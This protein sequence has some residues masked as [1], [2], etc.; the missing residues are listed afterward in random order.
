MKLNLSQQFAGAFS[1]IIAIL[2]GLI[3][4]NLVNFNKAVVSSRQVREES[5][6]FAITAK[7]LQKNV[8]QV[9]QFLTDVSATHDSAGY[10]EAKQNAEEFYSHISE[11]EKMFKNENDAENLKMVAE[12]RSSF[13]NFYKLG[14]EMAQA[15]IDKGMDAG[16]T[17]MKEFDPASEK[18]TSEVEK[19]ANSQVAELNKT[20]TNVE[21]ANKHAV[22]LNLILGLISVLLAGAISVVLS[23]HFVG[24]VNS[25]LATLR[26]IASGDLTRRVSVDSK[27]ELG[28]MAQNLNDTIKKVEEIIV[29][30]K[31]ATAQLNA[32]TEEISSSS[33]QISDGAQQQSASFEQLTSSVQANASNAASANEIAQGTTKEAEVAG[34]GMDHTIEAMAGIEKSSKQISDAVA[35]ITDIAE[36]TNLLALNAAIEA[37]RA[38]EHGKGFA[39]VADEVRKLAERSA[40]SAKEIVELINQSTKQVADGVKLSKNAGQSLKQIVVNIGKVADQIG[41]ISSATQEQAATMEENTSITESNASASEEL[42]ASA[43]EMAA[44]AEALQSM[45]DRFKTSSNEI[46][47]HALVQQ[48]QKKSVEPIVTEKV[49]RQIKRLEWK[50]VYATGVEEIDVQ[51][52][53]L[54]KMINELGD[55]I[56]AG[57]GPQAAP[58]ALKFLGDYVKTHFGYEEEC[59]HKLKCPVAHKNKEAHESFLKLFSKYNNR[60]KQEGYKDEVIYELHTVAVDWLVKHICGVDVNLKHC[61]NKAAVKA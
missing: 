10:Q 61:V 43:E 38:G 4:F 1:I 17:M 13:D 45:V 52:R 16:N 11:F 40:T 18:L 9:Q 56:K 60:F 47:K 36:Q 22:M 50:D 2:L 31:E 24:I 29:N 49:V 33:Q 14:Q 8:V 28:E 7:E 41:S 27:D 48:V 32:A 34:H 26:D 37:A 51:H 30:V 54:F 39:V 21:N 59:M 23:K 35:I 58:Q 19:L 55:A 12:I 3:T 25:V 15:Y 46:R 53:K 5:A 6:K 20:L 44:Q 42:A 57:Q